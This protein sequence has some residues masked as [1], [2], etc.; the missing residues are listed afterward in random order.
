MCPFFLRHI[1]WPATSSS[2]AL[3][4]PAL[5]VENSVAAKLT[6]GRPDAIMGY[7]MSREAEAK[8]VMDNGRSANQALSA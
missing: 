3:P 1:S 5:D 4:G 2:T 6:Y 8:E 7:E